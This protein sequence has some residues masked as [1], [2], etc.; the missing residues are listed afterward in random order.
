MRGAFQCRRISPERIQRVRVR[1]DQHQRGGR[2]RAPNV[3]THAQWA[4]RDNSFR[5]EGT[6]QTA[7]GSR[8]SPP[9]RRDLELEPN[10]YNQGRQAAAAPNG[11]HADDKRSIS[12]TMTINDLWQTM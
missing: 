7:Q 11:Q 5:V 12:M 6:L 3:I 9:P 4:T 8:R 10:D 2:W 1:Q